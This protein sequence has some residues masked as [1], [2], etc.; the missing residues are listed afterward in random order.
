[1]KL[2]RHRIWLAGL[3]L[4]A[5]TAIAYAPSWNGGFIWDDDDYVTTN[6]APDRARWLAPHLVFARFA[7]AIFPARLH[8]LSHRAR[9][10]GF[11]PVGLSLGQ[12]PFAHRKRA[13]PLALARAAESSGGVAG[14]GDL[15]AASGAGGIGRVD[16]GT[17]E[18]AHGIVLSPHPA[19]VDEVHRFRHE[20]ALGLLRA[21][22][23]LLP[24]RASQPR[25]PPAP[26]R[27]RCS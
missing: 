22:T 6:R 12:S 10:L 14:G 24:A 3:F 15:R 26:C 20:A 23:S 19:R 2:V 16:H 18:R 25:R 8:D 5:A 27:R 7:V 21:R 11:A 13:P 1:M 4:V 17:Q 9:P